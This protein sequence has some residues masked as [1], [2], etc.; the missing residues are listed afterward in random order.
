M[1]GG[2]FFAFACAGLA[3]VH[4]GGVVVLAADDVVVPAGKTG[5]C[6]LVD[7]DLSA[8]AKAEDSERSLR[9]DLSCVV[10]LG[11]FRRGVMHLQSILV[12]LHSPVRLDSLLFEGIPGA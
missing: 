2:I 12:G 10:T 1:P 5:D 3:E 9:H 7:L 4:G 11:A 6:D 8:G